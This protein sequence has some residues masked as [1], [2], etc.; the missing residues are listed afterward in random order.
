[1][2]IADQLGA[3]A[4][5]DYFLSQLKNRL[6]EWL[7]AG[8]GEQEYSYNDEWDVLTGYPSGFGAD[9]QINDHHFHSSYAIGVLQ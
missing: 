7:T 9:N 4:E 6:E 8:G 1:M 3:D 5:R 2:N